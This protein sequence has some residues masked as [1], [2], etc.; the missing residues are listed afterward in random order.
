MFYVTYGDEKKRK[1]QNNSQMFSRNDLILERIA[2]PIGLPDDE[3]R[4][5]LINLMK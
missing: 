1:R 4:D 2:K 5:K 3:D